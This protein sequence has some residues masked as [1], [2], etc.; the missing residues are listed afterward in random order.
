MT[1]PALDHSR[2]TVGLLGMAFKAR[3]STIPAHSL[4][5]KFRR[6]WGV[7]RHAVVT[8]KSSSPPIRICFRSTAVVAQSDVLILCARRGTGLSRA[9]FRW[10]ASGAS[11]GRALQ[12][13]EC[14]LGTL[15]FIHRRNASFP[16][17]PIHTESPQ[18]RCNSAGCCDRAV[19]PAQHASIQYGI[20]VESGHSSARTSARSE[21]VCPRAVGEPIRHQNGPGTDRGW[22]PHVADRWRDS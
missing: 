18:T 16:A 14:D 11:V 15:H 19:A 17:R 10:E 2:M 4:S 20:F 22:P 8:T 7:R 3:Q 5:Y 21:T 1:L 6:R 12:E 9:R 13:G